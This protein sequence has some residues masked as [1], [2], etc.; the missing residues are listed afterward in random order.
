MTTLRLS[1]VNRIR[2]LRSAGKSS[3]ELGRQ[4]GVTH[5]TILNIANRK[6]WR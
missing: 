1:Q 6:T 2:K 3:R 5:V 4:F